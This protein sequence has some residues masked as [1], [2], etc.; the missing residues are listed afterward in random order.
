MRQPKNVFLHIFCV[1]TQARLLYAL[2][3]SGKVLSSVNQCGPSGSHNVIASSKISAKL[4]LVLAVL[5]CTSLPLCHREMD[6]ALGVVIPTSVSIPRPSL[7]TPTPGLCRGGITV[8]ENHPAL[9]G[10]IRFMDLISSSSLSV[11]VR[12]KWGK[13]ISLSH[14]FLRDKA[15]LVAGGTDAF[16][17]CVLC[18]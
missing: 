13:L 12:M 17:T 2:G 4:T 8:L 15:A 14:V 7:S 6:L 16:F 1:E 5:K 9:G 10:E 18:L 11:V 3:D